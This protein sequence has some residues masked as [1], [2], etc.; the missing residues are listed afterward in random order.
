MESLEVKQ[1][2]LPTPDELA[3][4]LEV[5]SN[6]SAAEKAKE[7]WIMSVSKTFCGA[8]ATLMAADGDFGSKKMDATLLEVLLHARKQHPERS[9]AI[10][11]YI[12]T[13]LA[14]GW[15]TIEAG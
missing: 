1:Q 3:T 12:E 10:N 15:D 13:I 5:N 7:G 9:E 14:R 11:K 8:T 6:S 4:I 2:K